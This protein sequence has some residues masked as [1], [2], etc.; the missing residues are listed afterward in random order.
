M[1]AQLKS[2]EKEYRSFT[3]PLST[4]IKLTTLLPAAR[5]LRSS[6]LRANRANIR[7][8]VLRSRTELLQSSR[9]VVLAPN[10]V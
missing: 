8:I 9:A 2:V 1:A 6:L 4:A 10:Q 3:T 5:M 7:A